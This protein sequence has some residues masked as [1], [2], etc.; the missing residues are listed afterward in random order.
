MRVRKKDLTKEQIRMICDRYYVNKCK[1]CP[2]NISKTN[3]CIA[4]FNGLDSEDFDK[5]KAKAFQYIL[6]NSYRD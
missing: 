6:P 3:L 2:L 1:K 4:D 5:I